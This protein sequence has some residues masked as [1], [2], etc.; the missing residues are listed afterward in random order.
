RFS[1]RL[2]GVAPAALASALSS[3][4]GNDADDVVVL[5]SIHLVGSELPYWWSATYPA[6]F[7]PEMSAFAAAATSA[8]GELAARGNFSALPP[9]I[10]CSACSV[11]P[12][13]R[14]AGFFGLKR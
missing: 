8:A 4:P 9:T 5:M 11:P 1:G 7:A 2:N 14:L 13:C 6:E 10:T 3:A 12:A